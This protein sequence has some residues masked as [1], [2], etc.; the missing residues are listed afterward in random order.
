[1]ESRDSQIDPTLLS[2]RSSKVTHNSQMT[3]EESG[4]NTRHVDH[5]KDSTDD[6]GDGEDEDEDGGW[7]TTN[8]HHATHPGIYFWPTV[9]STHCIPRFSR[10]TSFSGSNLA[11]LASSQTRIPVFL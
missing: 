6:E 3:S 4:T 2:T 7:G 1:M 9:L 10:W 8:E 11:Q 5:S